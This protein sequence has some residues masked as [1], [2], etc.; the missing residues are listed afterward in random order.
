M[1]VSQFS[2][3]DTPEFGEDPTQGTRK[4]VALRTLEDAGLT[5]SATIFVGYEAG[6]AV[7]SVWFVARENAFSGIFSWHYS[8]TQQWECQDP[9]KHSMQPTVSGPWLKSR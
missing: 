5:P 6:R 8:K 3:G 2:V 4:P 7:M 9:T 1:V